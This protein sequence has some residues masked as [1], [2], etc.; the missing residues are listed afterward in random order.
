M[1][2][3]IKEVSVSIETSCIRVEKSMGILAFNK[4]HEIKGNKATELR[5]SHTFNL[6]QLRKETFTVS[7]VINFLGRVN[8]SF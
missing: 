7:L 3:K 4:V 1:L 5:F 6:F 2:N 8:I